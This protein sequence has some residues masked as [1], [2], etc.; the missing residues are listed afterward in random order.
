MTSL[1]SAISELQQSLSSS[2]AAQNWRWLVR[3]S[4]SNVREALN[5]EQ[6]RSWDGWLA[7]RS[8]TNDR[9]RKRLLARVAAIGP[10]VLERLDPEAAS[11]EVRRLLN[12]IEHYRQRVHDL[13][14]DSV[15]MEVGGSE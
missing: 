10:A 3:Q 5:D 13:I 4:L 15:S 14:Y 8:R 11:A 9:D 1:E 7:A 2:R 12:D 6:F